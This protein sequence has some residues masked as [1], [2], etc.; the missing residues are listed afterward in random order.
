M[1]L[2]HECLVKTDCMHDMEQSPTTIMAGCLPEVLSLNFHLHA[3]NASSFE[4]RCHH[5]KNSMSVSVPISLS[6]LRFFTTSP[7]P[8]LPHAG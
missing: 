8:G 5:G 1:Q 6:E 2:V 4:R 7:A 3:F